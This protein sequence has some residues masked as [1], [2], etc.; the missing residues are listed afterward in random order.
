MTEQDRKT[1]IEKMARMFI[2][3][4]AD[5]SIKILELELQNATLKAER[6]FYKNLA[7]QKS[8]LV[9]EW[10]GKLKLMSG[11]RK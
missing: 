6:D 7:N 5:M 11:D 9:S 4:Q 1:E 2:D 3:C 10:N 8:D